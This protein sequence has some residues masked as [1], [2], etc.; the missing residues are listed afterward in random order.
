MY[1]EESQNK[2][3]SCENSALSLPV[4]IKA[5]LIYRNTNLSGFATQPNGTSQNV[6]DFLLYVTN[7]ENFSYFRVVWTVLF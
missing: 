7:G 6:E 1:V 5:H 4:S 2:L 3:Y